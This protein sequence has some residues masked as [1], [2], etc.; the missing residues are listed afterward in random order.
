MPLLTKKG[1]AYDYRRQ[2]SPTPFQHYPTLQTL[3]KEVNLT[4]NAIKHE[5]ICY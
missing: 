5:K 3:K 4:S 1:I 2:D